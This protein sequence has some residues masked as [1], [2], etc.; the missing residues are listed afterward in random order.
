MR[1]LNFFFKKKKKDFARPRPQA[2]EN[3]RR[4]LAQVSWNLN[5]QAPKVELEVHSALN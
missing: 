4:G 3:F 5:L 2:L 1:I